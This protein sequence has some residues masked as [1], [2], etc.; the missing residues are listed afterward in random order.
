ML[1]PLV[2]LA[3]V[4]STPALAQSYDRAD[5]IRGLCRPDGCDE[6]AILAASP[7]TKGGEGTLMKTRVKTFHASSSGR[8]ELGEENGYVYCSRT[9]PAIVAEKGGRTMAFYLAPFATKQSRETIRQNANFHAL[10]FS[11]CH[12]L[13][14]GR[15]AA[16][17]LSGVAQKLGYRV[18]LP[19]S[20]SVAL[21]RVED[22][23]SPENRRPV[24]ARNDIRPMPPT[25]MPPAASQ[26]DWALD[27]P[28]DEFVECREVMPA[29]L[30]PPV[31]E[32]EEGL[33][34]GPRRLTNRAFDALDEMGDWVLGRRY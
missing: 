12:G 30:Y 19:Q 18:A 26:R 6:F 34:A 24:E 3:L 25:N 33:L 13:E 21:S 15:A 22:I 7:L 28:V 29:R 23:L 9:Q 31:V 11:I 1:R 17:N 16:Q 27:E 4:L 32:R 5:I 20:Q 14:V 2:A 10:Y 8:R